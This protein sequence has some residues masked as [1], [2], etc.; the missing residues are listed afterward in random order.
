LSYFT[1]LLINRQKRILAMPTDSSVQTVEPERLRYSEL[2]AILATRE[3]TEAEKLELQEVRAYGDLAED[4]AAVLQLFRLRAEAPTSE[5]SR[6]ALDK[7]LFT[8]AS[9]LQRHRLV[10]R[11]DSGLLL[12]EI[13]PA[14]AAPTP[15]ASSPLL[16]DQ[17][18]EQTAP[19]AAG[20]PAEPPA[21]QVPTDLQQYVSLLVSGDD[22]QQLRRLANR[23]GWS[24]DRDREAISEF[25]DR[26]GKQDPA[27]AEQ[28]RRLFYSPHSRHLF[29][30]GRLAHE[31]ATME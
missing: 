18:T 26:R 29:T 23:H 22:P 9:P 14:T 13:I 15:Q 30:A 27:S 5:H 20:P 4:L 17:P 16:A 24:P 31:P 10:Q 8:P 1:K 6:F 21:P 11:G 12:H 19:A 3:L 7:L 25:I 28:R 2:L